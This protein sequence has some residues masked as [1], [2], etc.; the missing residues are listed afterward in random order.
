MTELAEALGEVG[1][2]DRLRVTTEDGTA[3]EGRASPVDYVPEESL[4]IEV[5]PEDGGVDRYE[6]RA[7]YDDGWSD[8]LVRHAEADAED[9]SWTELGRVG[10]F[11]AEE[12]GG[13][14]G[15]ESEPS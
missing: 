1:V 13:Q 7:T 14:S 5:R 4:R 8:P 6:I 3:F 10:E 12:Q 9:G 15:P 2:D 11:A